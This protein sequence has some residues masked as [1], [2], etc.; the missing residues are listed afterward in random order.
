VPWHVG[1]T[2]DSGHMAATQRTDPS[3]QTETSHNWLV[4]FCPANLVKRQSLPIS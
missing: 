2:S 3:G 1:F 4:Q